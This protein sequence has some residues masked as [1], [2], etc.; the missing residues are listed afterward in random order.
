MKKKECLYLICPPGG[1]GATLGCR[2][3]LMEMSGGE[4][5]KLWIFHCNFVIE[6]SNVSVKEKERNIW[7]KQEENTHTK[8][9]MKRKHVWLGNSHNIKHMFESF[10]GH[11]VVLEKKLKHR[12][13]IFTVLSNFLHYW[14]W[15]L[16]AE[17]NKVMR[18]LFEV[19]KVAGS[20]KERKKEI[21]RCS[22]FSS[23]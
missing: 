10:E 13:L 18:T 16:F 15:K 12:V 17:E 14:M 4:T 8:S 22:V 19:R 23:D 20:K 6:I 9:D 3:E 11:Y 7:A 21:S 1:V 2:T 5:A